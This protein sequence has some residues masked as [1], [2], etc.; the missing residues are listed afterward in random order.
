[1]KIDLSFINAAEFFIIFMQNFKKKSPYLKYINRAEKKTT[2]FY[3]EIN[4]CNL[5]AVRKIKLS[6][7]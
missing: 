5:A 6:V 1:M 2:V 7:F 4:F 3:L